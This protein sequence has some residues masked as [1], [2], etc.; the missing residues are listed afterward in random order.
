MA[1]FTTALLLGLAAGGGLAAG[2]KLGQRKG[3][4]AGPQ[5]TDSLMGPP[6]TPPTPALQAQSGAIATAMKARKRV[7]TGSVNATT[8]PQATGAQ[9]GISYVG[10]NPAA[11]SLLGGSK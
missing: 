7:P 11:F 1:A 8:A 10:R 3:V 9:R 6:P 2:K 5:P 4:P